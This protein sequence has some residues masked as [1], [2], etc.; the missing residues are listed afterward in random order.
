L[1]ARAWQPSGIVTLL[2]DFGTSDPY[3]G[4]M[5]GVVLGIAAQA[6]LVDLTHEVAPQSVAAGALLLRSAVE[7]FPPGTVHLAVVDPGVGGARAPIV[8]VTDR[9]VLVGPDNG[10]LQPSWEILGLREIRRIEA[11]ELFLQPVSRTFHGR[12]IFAPVAAHLAAGRSPR[13]IGPVLDSARPLQGLPGAGRLEPDGDVIHGVILHVDRFGNLISNVAAAGL[14]GV[15]VEIAGRR[16]AGLSSSYSEVP[17]G[18]IVALEG[19]WGTV[20]IA[21]NRGS[22]A[23]VL[24]CGVGSALLVRRQS[25]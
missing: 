12:D 3:V 1:S 5:H 8:A 17:A 13:S 21:C 10:L 19:S 25:A 11:A 22:A 9:A 16:V 24:G 15:T 7:Y 14:G 18:D 20:E 4:I 6:R 2:S 23:A